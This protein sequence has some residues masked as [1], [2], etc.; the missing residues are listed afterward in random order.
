[1]GE[2]LGMIGR[3]S[4]ALVAVLA[5]ALV[6]A[7][8]NRGNDAAPVQLQLARASGGLVKSIFGGRKAQARPEPTRAQLEA[9]GESIISLV[10]ERR[11]MQAYLYMADRH[12]DD[13]PG[14]LETWRTT[15]EGASLTLR[16]GVLVTTRGF[17]G[18]L[19]STSVELQ[20]GHLGPLP[21]A[22]VQQ[23]RVSDNRKRALYLSCDMAD[24]GPEPVVILGKTHAT[25]H[26]QQRC[27]GGGGRVVN[28]FW[29]DA[30]AGMIWQSRQWAGP[31]VGYLRVQRV[32]K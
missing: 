2:G 8:C 30:R 6:L 22:V 20:D 28:D 10:A 1:M 12:R 7:G 9:T 15:D 29:T 19:L 3:G 5:A 24:L 23:I 13:L 26:L 18:D 31:E 14:V 27:E 11:E 32:T 21:G 17:G 16:D 4:R 25:R